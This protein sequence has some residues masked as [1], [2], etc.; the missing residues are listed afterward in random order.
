MGTAAASDPPHIE[1]VMF[2]EVKSGS[3]CLNHN[4]HRLKEAIDNRRVRWHESRVPIPLTQ[5]AGH[6]LEPTI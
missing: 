1:E 6:T 3:A 2:V 4:E 5:S